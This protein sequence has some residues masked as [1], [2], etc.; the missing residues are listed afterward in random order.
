MV[1]IRRREI[2]PKID[3]SWFMVHALFNMNLH[4]TS[5]L[6][7]WRGIGVCITLILKQWCPCF[8]TTCLI[9]REIFHTTRKWELWDWERLDRPYWDS[10]ESRNITSISMFLKLISTYSEIPLWSV[11]QIVIKIYY[12]LVQSQLV[13]QFNPQ[14]IKKLF[15]FFVFIPRLGCSI[16]IL[17]LPFLEKKNDYWMIL[18]I[19]NNSYISIMS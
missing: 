14:N 6:T 13:T 11:M 18:E 7:S 1:L 2:P 19:N 15:S 16:N 12:L 4:V 17:F 5:H 8:V 9:T 10:L 3:H